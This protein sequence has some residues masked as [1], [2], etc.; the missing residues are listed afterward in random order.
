MST[1]AQGVILTEIID[2]ISIYK[3][4][5]RGEWCAE[6][7]QGHHPGWANK[8][9]EENID[10]DF[11]A[12]MSYTRKGP[13]KESYYPEDTPRSAL[14]KTEFY[15]NPI[16]RRARKRNFKGLSAPEEEVRKNLKTRKISY[17]AKPSPYRSMAYDVNETL[18]AAEAKFVPGARRTTNFQFSEA[19]LKANVSDFFRWASKNKAFSKAARA[20]FAW[21]KAHW[22]PTYNLGEVYEIFGVRGGKKFLEKEFG[23]T[24]D[25]W[26]FRHQI[27]ARS[28][29]VWNPEAMAKMSPRERMAFLSKNAKAI[30]PESVKKVLEA[31]LETYKPIEKKRLNTLAKQLKA[32]VITKKEYSK[33][34]SAATGARIKSRFFQS[35]IAVSRGMNFS[36]EYRAVIANGKVVDITYRWASDDVKK[37]LEKTPAL[38]KMIK[39]IGI[40]SG[41]PEIIFRVSK[42]EASVITP[43]AERMA[44][45]KRGVYAIDIGREA[46]KKLAQEALW[47]IE[48]QDAF[49]NITQPNV[50]WK[51]Y[52]RLTGK[53]APGRMAAKMGG[54]AGLMLAGALLAA[55][56][57]GGKKKDDGEEAQESLTASVREKLVQNPTMGYNQVYHE[58]RT[59]HQIIDVH[60]KTKH[61]FRV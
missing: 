53:T 1:S 28:Q 39:G 4:R 19:Y 23:Q 22:V 51:I 9:T 58:N 52:E 11:T 37:M 55:Q 61:L 26:W 7:I 24:Q 45:T 27:S 54:K 36:Q 48:F 46:G 35:D 44:K 25:K 56:V 50:E 18:V 59:S 16:I 32:G 38:K 30:Y 40:E 47:G 31:Y 6:K 3:S 15:D 33:L 5:Q 42:E 13:K 10:S 14:R 43:W 41:M 21:A 34:V 2:Q 29:A 17:P 60:E 49:G 8:K 20:D 57:L 12:G